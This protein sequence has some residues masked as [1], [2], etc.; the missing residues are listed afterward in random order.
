MV[1]VTQKIMAWVH[2]SSLV[3]TV[4]TSP[5]LSLQFTQR[6]RIQASIPAGES[7]SPKA[8]VLG[9]STWAAR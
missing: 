2:R 9:P 3:K 8:S 4:S 6:S 5:P 1:L 7:D